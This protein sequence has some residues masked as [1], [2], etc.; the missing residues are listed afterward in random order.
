MISRIKSGHPDQVQAMPRTF[1]F[2]TDQPLGGLFPR[3]QS[4]PDAAK[5][6]CIDFADRDD[7]PQEIS[8]QRLN[9]A[10]K[11]RIV[12]PVFRTSDD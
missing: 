5:L 1:E 8:E 10:G 3:G 6:D 9:F 2:P 12:P 4:H 7:F 11:P